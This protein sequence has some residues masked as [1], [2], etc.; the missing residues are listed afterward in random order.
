M[1]NSMKNLVDK[2]KKAFFK[3]IYN[4]Y[5]P[6][7]YN[8]VQFVVL[9]HV[10]LDLVDFYNELGNY[11]E[12]RLLM[13]IPYSLDTRVLDLLSKKTTQVEILKLD[14]L[15]DPVYL[16]EIFKK[17]VDS[18]KETIIVEVGGYFAPIINQIKECMGENL[19]GVV[20]DTEAGHLMYSNL[21]ELNVPVYSVA[22]SDLK[23]PEDALIGTS[24]VCAT[25]KLIRKNKGLFNNHTA[26]VL[27]YGKIGQG[28]A[29]VLHLLHKRVLVYDTNPILRALA[30]SHGFS[31]PTRQNAIKQANFIYGA[32]ANHSIKLRDLEL[33]QNGAVLI[34]CSSRAKE[35]DIDSFEKKYGKLKI[36]R[37]LE[38]Y[39]KGN[40]NFYL[41][42][43][44]L[45]INFKNGKILVGPI[46]SLVRGE[47][48]MCVTKLMSSAKIE[49]EVM[50]ISYKE[51][52]ELSFL[53][54][55]YFVDK[56]RGGYKS[57]RQ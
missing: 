47:I 34:S 51:K 41:A 19:L 31:I 20:E 46:I 29:R 25:K 11:G 16:L 7:K 23:S 44:G 57:G 39:E 14:Q 21:N 9:T 30:L 52:Q 35:Y 5:L 10:V 22:R 37:N 27:G 26:L 53:W 42:A 6:D 38:R 54:L 40:Y 1:K 50:E 36:S 28:I 17:N 4:K 18:N 43:Y 15:S 24:C 49:H 13:P 56:K 8:K 33:L 45:P 55:N 12:I 48:A 32:T 3:N 2:R